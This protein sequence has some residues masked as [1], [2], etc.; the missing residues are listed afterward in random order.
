MYTPCN[1]LP[2]YHFSTKHT[3]LQLNLSSF[4]IM[5]SDA[6][7]TAP[8][9]SMHIFVCTCFHVRMF[10]VLLFY[11]ILIPVRALL[12]GVYKQFNCYVSVI[13]HGISYLLDDYIICCLYSII[14]CYQ[15]LQQMMINFYLIHMHYIYQD[16]SS[17]SGP[18]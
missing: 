16:R 7:Q 14:L 6:S 17:N 4:Q 1:K 15:L 18:C 5:S 11:V 9:L 8:V 10:H 2:N 12:H 13:F 3:K